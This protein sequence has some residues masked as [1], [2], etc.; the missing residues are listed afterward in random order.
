MS[1]HSEWPGRKDKLVMMSDDSS[2]FAPSVL[3]AEAR[4]EGVIVICLGEPA[5]NG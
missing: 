4:I 5:R 1:G 2:V 3:L